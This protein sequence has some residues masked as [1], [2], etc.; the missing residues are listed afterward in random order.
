MGGQPGARRL[1][2]ADFPGETRHSGVVRHFELEYEFCLTIVLILKRQMKFDE[3]EGFLDHG[4]CRDGGPVPSEAVRRRG[5]LVSRS[6]G[7]RVW[8]G[9]N[10]AQRRL[11]G[12]SRGVRG[13]AEAKPAAEDVGGGAR[14]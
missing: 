10:G 7:R 5:R 11:R 9:T 8:R 4:P 2:V 3:S 6:V 1:H 12:P 14:T 13:G